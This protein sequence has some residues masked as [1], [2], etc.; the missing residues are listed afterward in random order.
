VLKIIEAVAQGGEGFSRFTPGQI[1]IA[2]IESG[3]VVR[4]GDGAVS[5]KELQIEGK[6]RMN[7][8]LFLRGRKLKKGTT[9]A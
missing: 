5:I 3:L 8:E 1:A 7:T 6:R 9:L 2:D 4:T